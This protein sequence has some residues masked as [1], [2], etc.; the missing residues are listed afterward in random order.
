MIGSGIARYWHT[1]RH[2]RPVQVHGRLWFRLYRPRPDLAPAPELVTAV[3]PWKA[4]SRPPSMSGP[5]R[6]SFLGQEHELA[7]A[8]DWNRS[9]WSR[10]WLY[11]A[12]YFDDLVADGADRRRRWHQALIER[13]LTDNPPACGTGWEPYPTSL[14][15]VNWLK[16]DAADLD[17]TAAARHSLAVQARHLERRLEVHLQGNHLW[18][19]AKTLVFVGTRHTGNEADRWLDK[20]L[21][22]MAQQV[23]EQILDDGGHYERSPMYHAIVLEDLLDLLQLAQLHPGRI[24]AATVQAWQARIPAMLRWLA[25]MTHPDGSLARFND[26]AAGIA[27]DLAALTRYATQLRITAPTAPDAALIALPASG[28]VRLQLGPAVLLADVG[29]VGPD[30]QPGHAHADTLACELSLHGQRLLVNAGT[31]TYAPGALRAWQRGTEAH[32]TVSVDGEDSS[33]V[34][35]AFRV[36]RRARVHDVAWGQDEDGLWLAASHDGYQRLPGRVT[37]RRRWRLQPG[38]LHIQDRLEGRFDEAVARLRLAPGTLVE[39]QGSHHGHIVHAGKAL[40]WHA[41]AVK[42]VRIQ[43]SHC[44]PAFGQ[45]QACKVLE[46]V[47]APGDNRFEIQW[48]P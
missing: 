44:Y 20:G 6:L 19:N 25:A 22:L 17:L 47:L 4:C 7:R 10:L 13:W 8:S 28:Y 2:L 39:Q 26:C 42:Q 48:Q 32:N 18:A 37:H 30:H 43:D 21:T 40:A 12:H 45:R 29:A 38:S 24:P 11:N 27:P 15:I 3:S 31:S 36:A 16:A 41:G 35:A 34:W 1:V 5:T 46:L 14:R 9:D 23:P 33:E